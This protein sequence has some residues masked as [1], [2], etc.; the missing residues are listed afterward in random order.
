MSASP[1]NIG[2]RQKQIDFDAWCVK[3]NLETIP[4]HDEIIITLFRGI[5]K[6]KTFFILFR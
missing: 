6:A 3:T 4:S 5:F 2:K 1:E